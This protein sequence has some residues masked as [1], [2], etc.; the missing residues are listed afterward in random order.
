[1]PALARVFSGEGAGCHFHKPRPAAT[2]REARHDTMELTGP[3][4]ESS[5][6][7]KLGDSDLASHLE[8]RI[9]ERTHRRVQQLRVEL[10]EDRLIIH[11]W[12]NSRYVKQL[13]LDAV[14]E[15]GRF[16]TVEL[17]IAVTGPS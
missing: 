1:L 8:H 14:G 7:P 6:I 16:S 10:D 2:I 15:V 17:K 3:A 12:V 4:C 13:A 11:G 5:R 9:N